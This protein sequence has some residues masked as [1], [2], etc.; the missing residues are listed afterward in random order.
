MAER[1]RERE[2]NKESGSER[3]PSNKE[4]KN[5]GRGNKE[6]SRVKMSNENRKR[7]YVGEEGDLRELMEKRRNEIHYKIRH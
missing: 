3:K 7:R 5:E 1:G 2:V 4:R 6:N